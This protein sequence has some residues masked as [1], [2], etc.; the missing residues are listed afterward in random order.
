MKKIPAKIL[1]IA[2]LS[3]LSLTSFAWSQHLQIFNNSNKPIDYS[4]QAVGT[5]HIS[6]SHAVIQPYTSLS[7]ST[8]DGTIDKFQYWQSQGTISLKRDGVT[9]N[10]QYHGWA[11]YHP[12][13]FQNK[14]NN[15]QIINNSRKY[16]NGPMN[17]IIVN[18]DNSW[19]KKALHAQGLLNQYEPI[20]N[21]QIFGTH[22]SYISKVYGNTYTVDP[23]QVISLRAQLDAGV[24]AV[25][26]DLHY[27]ALRNRILL[28]HGHPHNGPN[29]MPVG[30]AAWDNPLEDGL[31]EI[32]SWLHDNLQTAPNTFI[33]LYLD[34]STA[35]HWDMMDKIFKD[36]L[37]EYIFSRNDLA[38]YLQQHQLPTDNLRALPA[39]RVTQQDILAAGK[40]I[41]IVTKSEGL[42][43]S[44]FV[45]DQLPSGISLPYDKGVGG[46][47]SMATSGAS[48][49]NKDV[50]HSSVWRVYD[51]ETNLSND[52]KYLN[53]GNIRQLLAF[54]INW[55]C[56][57]KLAQDDSRLA[58]LIWAWDEG[59]PLN[60]SDARA[61]PYAVLVNNPQNQ[62]RFHNDIDVIQQPMGVLCHDK[63]QPNKA[64][65]L[66]I[67]SV[68]ISEDI[69]GSAN[70]ACQAK[71]YQFAAPV[72]SY[73]M[74]VAVA[75]AKN[76]PQVLVNMFYQNGTWVAN[77][78]QSLTVIP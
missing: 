59:Y 36:Q 78:K 55:I 27:I 24:T 23:N 37:G 10:I 60:S 11:N 33:I 22:N 64:G 41:L 39:D 54:R 75:A 50:N 34:Q 71:G 29:S 20:N 42:E 13:Q 30:C 5:S 45:F 56:F 3:S 16:C 70:Q 53:V 12:L 18:P 19:V 14:S 43:K 7:V 40:H 32:R 76:V 31:N 77:N 73:S 21:Q 74:A 6:P 25:E 15:L 58:S 49:F 48:I 61:K 63:N 62:S 69:V 8:G 4:A 47:P 65:W 52:D 2:L 9:S 35:G 57:D 1:N 51:D 72:N 44:Q 67:P 28:C 66:V 68:K 26:I 38:N 46:V 17:C